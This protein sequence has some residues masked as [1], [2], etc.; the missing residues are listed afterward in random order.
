MTMF[1]LREYIFSQKLLMSYKIPSM[2]LDRWT[3]W[4]ATVVYNIVSKTNTEPYEKSDY[5]LPS[6]ASGCIFSLLLLQAGV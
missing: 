6:L 5:I 1:L 3:H 4:K 2:N